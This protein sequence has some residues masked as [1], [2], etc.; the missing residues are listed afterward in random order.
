MRKKVFGE[1]ALISNCKLGVAIE[2]G[3]GKSGKNYLNVTRDVRIILRNLG[4]LSG[5]KQ[6]FSKK[7][8]YNVTGQYPIPKACKINNALRE[9]TQIKKGQIVGHINKKPLVAP[10]SFY[11]LFLGEGRYE[12]TLCLVAKTK[13]AVTL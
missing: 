6:H 8:T 1:H 12:K 2:Y 5:N 11:P 4:L 9:Y 3:S 10:Y 13:K 7:N